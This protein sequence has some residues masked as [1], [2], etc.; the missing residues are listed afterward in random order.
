MCCDKKFMGDDKGLFRRWRDTNN[1]EESASLARKIANLE[2][3]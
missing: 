3:R 1:I 2:V